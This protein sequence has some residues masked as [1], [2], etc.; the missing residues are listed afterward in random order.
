MSC[1]FKNS[2]LGFLSLSVCVYIHSYICIHVCC[3]GMIFF[4][5]LFESKFRKEAMENSQEAMA[6]LCGRDDGLVA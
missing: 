2:C 5:K 4:S 3:V 1:V 6:L